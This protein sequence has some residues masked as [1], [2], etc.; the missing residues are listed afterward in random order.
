MPPAA[1][2]QSVFFFSLLRQSVEILFDS[3]S[4]GSA[5][6]SDADDG[7]DG[8]SSPPPSLLFSCVVF[9][10]EPQMSVNIKCLCW[11]LLSTVSRVC[12]VL[13]LSHPSDCLTTVQVLSFAVVQ[14]RLFLSFMFSFL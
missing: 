12:L 13:H 6:V 11:D 8:G 2:T 5:V 10:P 14:E 9:H 3:I 7:D 4:F 1:Q